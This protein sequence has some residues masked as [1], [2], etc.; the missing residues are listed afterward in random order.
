MHKKALMQIIKAKGGL[1][2]LSLGKFLAGLISV[3]V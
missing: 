1:E 3:C 2:H